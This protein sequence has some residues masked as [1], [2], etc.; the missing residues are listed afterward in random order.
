MSIFRW[1]LDNFFAYFAWLGQLWGDRVR[2]EKLEVRSKKR[3]GDKMGFDLRIFEDDRLEAGYLDWLTKER[4]G[5]VQ[6]HFGRMWDYYANPMVEITAAGAGQRAAEAGRCYVQAQEAGL[7]A[8]ITGVVRNPA[9]GVFGGRAVREIQ[10]K[11]V[12][13]ENDIAWRIN[14]A[15]D[16]L[17]G[18][19]VSF[20]SRSPDAQ[21]RAEIEAIIKSVFGANGG[22]GFFQDMAVLGGVYGFVDCFVRPGEEIYQNF[23]SASH[24]N[25]PLEAVLRMAQ[26]IELELIEAPRALPILDESNY[27]RILYYV[28]HFYLKRNAVKRR[29][30]F[31]SRL[32][33]LDGTEGCQTTAVTEIVSEKAWQRYEDGE[34]VGEGTTGG[35]FCRWCIY[36]IWRS[37]FIMRG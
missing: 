32:L 3:T 14:A 1:G 15:V 28:Q 12:V 7:P 17:F 29:N 16:F 4:A 13:I 6:R 8:R 2:S 11:E 35:D 19:P 34:L 9:A 22:V 24:Q 18:K 21:K 26:A 23:T 25:F 5:Q 30:S 27:K 37:H 20:V 10:R 36:R 33:G 31:L